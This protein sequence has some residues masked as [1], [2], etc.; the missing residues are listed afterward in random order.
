MW[1]LVLWAL[2]YPHQ[3]LQ[4]SQE[5]LSLAHELSHPFSLAMALSQVSQFHGC[6]GSGR[7]PRSGPRHDRAG[8]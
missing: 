3:A 8:A 6:A 2:G 7:Q 4:R 5:G 1:R